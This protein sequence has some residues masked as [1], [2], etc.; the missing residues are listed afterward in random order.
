MFLFKFS[1]EREL[2]NFFLGWNC[3]NSYIKR[4]KEKKL[5]AYTTIYIEVLGWIWIKYAHRGRAYSIAVENKI[6]SYNLIFNIVATL[7]T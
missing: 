4:K 1:A 5:V 7:K 2:A 3:I 6:A